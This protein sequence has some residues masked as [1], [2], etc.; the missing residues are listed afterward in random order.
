MWAVLFHP[1][2]LYMFQGR[3]LL[4]ARSKQTY[5][6]GRAVPQ[7]RGDISRGFVSSWHQQATQEQLHPHRPRRQQPSSLLGLPWQDWRVKIV[8]YLSVY[9]LYSYVEDDCSLYQD[10]LNSSNSTATHSPIDGSSTLQYIYRRLYKR[11]TDSRYWYLLSDPLIPLV[12][13]SGIPWTLLMFL[14]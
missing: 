13:T 4:V 5:P 2:T 3:E 11:P 7:E 10:M 9:K 12:C 1:N 14:V 6:K 8:N